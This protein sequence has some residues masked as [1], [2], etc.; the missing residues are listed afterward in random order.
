MNF[1]V[2]LSSWENDCNNHCSRVASQQTAPN[3]P[4]ALSTMAGGP[5]LGGASLG[6][7]VP[8]PTVIQKNAG[9]GFN[10]HLPPARFGLMGKLLGASMWFF[11]FYRARCVDL[12][13]NPNSVLT[14]FA[15]L[16]LQARRR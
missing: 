9:P 1:K 6:L 8:L 16:A 12:L 7:S 3:F 15:L 5:N 13:S 4:L 14:F 2:M 10:P 11:I